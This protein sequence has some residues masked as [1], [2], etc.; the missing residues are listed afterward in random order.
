MTPHALL[1]TL[2]AIGISETVYLIRKRIAQERPVC[3]I[4]QECH[5]V[6]ESKYNK[7]LGI[8]TDITGLVF[9]V[10]ISLITAFLVIGLEPIV[11]LDRLA[12]VLILGGAF[13]SLYFIYLQWRVIKAWC[14]WCLIS[15]FTTFFMALI[16]LTSDLTFVI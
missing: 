11:W 6:L 3:I 15:A 8:P 16:V 2:A 1:F 12:K 14:L 4:G 7:I 10:V 5:Q 13:V 9:Y